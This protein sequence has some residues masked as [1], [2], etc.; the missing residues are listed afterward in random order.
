MVTASV[1]GTMP[2]TERRAMS[3]DQNNP[4]AM[5]DSQQ[6]SRPEASFA[7]CPG[8][9]YP[10][11]YTVDECLA[12][13][14]TGDWNAGPR[15]AQAMQTLAREVRRLRR[16]EAHYEELATAIETKWRL[17]QRTPNDQAHL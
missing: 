2:S 3:D 4:N 10:R 14:E 17:N 6:P 16:V 12:W 5:H 13:A 8:S 1:D 11:E 9:A 15:S 7:P